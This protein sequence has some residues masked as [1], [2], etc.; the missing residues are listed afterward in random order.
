MPILVVGAGA[1][2]SAIAAG[3]VNSG[4]DV[5]L[6]ARGDRLAHLRDNPVE[7]ES[8]GVSRRTPVAVSD[9]TGLARPAAFAILCTKTGDLAVALGD[10]ARHLAPH[11]VV[12]TLQNGVEAPDQ[13][14][15]A[16]PQSAI[17]AGRVHGFFEMDGHRVRHVGVPPSVAMGGTNAAG[18]A[19]EHRVAALL[20]RAGFAT[21]VAADVLH[22]LWEKLL[23]TAG[24]GG[25]AA[26]LGVSAGQV[27][28]VPGGE[29]MLRR[30]LGE[31]ALVARACGTALGQEDIERTVA[32]IRGFPA[33]ATTSL[34]RDL[35]SGGKSEYDALVG[36]VVRRAAAY[37][38]AVPTF[39]A[40]DAQLRA[41][42]G[43]GS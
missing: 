8:N 23:I 21:K 29:D 25:V 39:A 3:L 18:R 42:H 43:V 1:I 14:A 38:L 41:R 17:V 28:G 30:A 12:L 32:F 40:L 22:D 26:T 7:L 20:S 31:V 37:G 16:L 5:V 27:L 2:G 11:A 9:W 33:E 10:L 36:A 35:D 19:Y 13:A 6:L 34:Q 24:L 4:E 15:L